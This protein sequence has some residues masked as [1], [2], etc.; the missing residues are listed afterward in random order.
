MSD[1]PQA[2]SPIDDESWDPFEL[3]DRAMGA[4]TC[5]DPYPEFAVSRREAPVQKIDLVKLMGEG[6]R[7]MGQNMPEIYGAFSFEAVSQ[8]LR[9]GK[10]FSSGGYKDT[11]GLVMGPTILV[12]D[13]PEHSRYRGLIQTAFRSKALERWETDLVRPI[14]N[15]Y[16]DRFVSRGRADLVRELTFPF[17]VF[18]IAGMLGLPER[19]L[20]RFHRWT[21]GL[22]SVAFDFARGLA[23]SKRLG[24]YL[25]AIIEERRARPQQ[26]IISVLTQAELDG[27]RLDNE[28]I[29]GFLRLLLPAGAE[30]TYRSSSN[31]LFGLLTH[32]EQLA[33]VRADRS[34]IPRATEE[35][36]RWE[37]PLTGIG[38]L[39]VEDTD[40]CGVTIPKGAMVTVSLGSANH[41][42]TRWERP[43]EFDIF[44]PQKQHMAFAFGPHR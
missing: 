32:P 30:T 25:T 28:H 42:E 29:L 16:I 23:A 38:R 6:A 9:D 24:E 1:Q 22:I 2:A 20:P 15:G 10:R 36:L 5:R 19:D 17:P 41:D 8:V 18:V 27:N 21:V 14:V 39:C 35:G 7:G 31:L 12:M 3:F 37:T 13:E 40:V 11:I 26:D 43:D 44:R 4:D 34:L 33:A